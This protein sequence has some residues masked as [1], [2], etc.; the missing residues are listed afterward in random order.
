MLLPG[1]RPAPAPVG[2]VK[3]LGRVLGSRG[4]SASAGLVCAGEGTGSRGVAQDATV[5]AAPAATTTGAQPAT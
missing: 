3:R 1:Y 5:N 2:D 4:S